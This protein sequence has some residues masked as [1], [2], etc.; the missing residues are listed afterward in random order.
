MFFRPARTWHF[1]R[2]ES[3]LRRGAGILRGD[4]GPKYAQPMTVRHGYDLPQ[5]LSNVDLCSQVSQQEA[6]AV[7]EGTTSLLP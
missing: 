7:C 4:K 3:K 1:V 6:R 5:I 2:C